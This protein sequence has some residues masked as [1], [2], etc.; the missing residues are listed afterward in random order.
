M[1]LV[2][3]KFAGW[4]L[5][6]LVLGVA[7]AYAEDPEVV[8]WD[9]LQPADNE[10][11]RL[12]QNDKQPPISHGSMQSGLPLQMAG[13]V[14][15][16]L[17]MTLWNGL[18]VTKDTPQDVRDKIIAVAS[19]TVMSERAQNIAKETGALVYW[20]NAGDSAA[21]IANDIATMDRIGE[22]LQ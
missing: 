12:S 2:L 21:R 19:K 22:L 14:V 10:L 11:D 5:L 13:E 6:I 15:P 8:M 20:Q 18:F 17:G 4:S 1:A 3:R 7:P 16:E 9:D